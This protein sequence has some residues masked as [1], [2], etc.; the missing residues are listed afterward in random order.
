M[1]EPV[2]DGSKVSRVHEIWGPQR[3]QIIKETKGHLRKGQSWRP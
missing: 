2:G 1:E 3:Y